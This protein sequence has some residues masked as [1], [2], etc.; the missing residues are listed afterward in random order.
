MQNINEF[1]KDELKYFSELNIVVLT[2]IGDKPDGRFFQ[3]AMN[4]M[5]YSWH[6]GLK[7]SECGI[8][9]RTVVDWARNNLARDALQA[10]DPFCGKKYTHFLWLDSDMVF[11][12]DLACQLARHRVDMVSL[13][14]CARAGAPMPLIYTHMDDDEEG[15][16][17]HNL[18]DIPKM[19]CKC[20]AFGFGG[21]LI[22][23]KVFE[24]TPEP[25]FT[26]DYRAGED[27]AFCKRARDFGFQPYVD[28]AYSAGHIGLPGVVSI[29]DWEKWKV[30]NEQQYLQD[31][32]Q[33]NLGG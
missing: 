6:H 16:K 31:R 27:I 14:Y 33:V 28:G 20:D 4:M 7:V 26:I 18:L 19:L 2:P 21:C 8:T 17:H 3:S 24:G 13:V 25:W 22:S 1:T 12:S 5:A 15:Y 9:E 29:K 11:N 32:V 30:D 23:R 10:K